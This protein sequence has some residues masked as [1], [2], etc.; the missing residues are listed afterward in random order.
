MVSVSCPDNG[1]HRSPRDH[2]SGPQSTIRPNRCAGSTPA[3]SLSAPT[4]LSGWR[5]HQIACCTSPSPVPSPHALT[6]HEPT[7]CRGVRAPGCRP[8]AHE[9]L[10]TRPCWWW[11]TYA[12]TRPTPSCFRIPDRHLDRPPLRA[13]G[14]QAARGDGADPGPVDR[15]RARKG[16]RCT[17]GPP[18]IPSTSW[19]TS[20]STCTSATETSRDAQL[21]HIREEGAHRAADAAD[22]TVTVWSHTGHITVRGTA[23]LLI[24]STLFA[25]QPSVA[26]RPARPMGAAD[27][28]SHVR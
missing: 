1:Q 8:C 22:E 21:I 3:L 27:L 9:P 5:Y 26:F 18:T 19:V 10:V 7:A 15:G 28:L 13:G 20:S 11:P 23:S 6:G 24:V 14:D 2:V 25:P 17:A 12:R 16:P 4:K